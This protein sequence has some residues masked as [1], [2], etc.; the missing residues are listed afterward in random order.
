MKVCLVVYDNGT[1]LLH[2]PQGLAAV[3]ATL[4]QEG[5]KVTIWD[6]GVNHYPSHCLTQFLDENEFD[7]VGI[8][9]IAGYWQYKILLELSEAIDASRH[10]PKHYILGGYGPAPEPE[11]FLRKTNADI[12]VIGEG[13]DTIR[14]LFSVLEGGKDLSTINGIAY[15]DGDTIRIAPERELIPEE[16][17]NDLNR[18]PMPAYDLFE[19]NVYRLMRTPSCSTVHFVQPMLS[20]RGCPFKCNFCYRMDKGH[21]ERDISSMLE[22]IDYLMTDFGINYFLFSDDLLMTSKNR[23]LEISKEFLKWQNRTGKQF[24]WGCNGRLNYATPEVLQLMEQAGCSFI[25]YGIEAFDDQVLRTMKKSLT[26]KMIENGIQETLKTSINPGL[27]IIW[28]NHG[29]TVET[30]RKSVDFLIKY[31]DHTQF[32]TVKPVA[33]YPGS[34][35]YY[36][37]IMMGLLD[38]NNPAEDF[39]ENK[40]LNSEL[41]TVN[42]T[43][44]TDS[45]FYEALA[46]GNKRLVDDYFNFLRTQHH[47]EIDQLYSEQNNT[48]RGFR[49]KLVYI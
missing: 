12:V 47:D 41:L 7:V 32:R 44:L 24:T 19:M 14:E 17:L 27:N 3:A 45:D 30:L 20:G 46:A 39:Y 1:H 8:S 11:Y 23:T 35:L 18:V 6:Q 29:E 49:S 13:E 22:E 38:S 16:C 2:F 34:P 10:R 48:H 21:R 5:H 31:S 9:L 15:R 40:H 28:G 43:Q 25:N 42:F 37:A 4:R 33:P 26:V 36:D